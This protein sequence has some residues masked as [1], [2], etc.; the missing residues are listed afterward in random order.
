MNL[1]QKLMHIEMPDLKDSCAG[2]D[3]AAF[4]PNIP[5]TPHREPAETVVSALGSDL[6]LGL[7][8][9]EAQRRLGQYGP[10]R[11]EERA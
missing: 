7:T 8:R 5:I 4:G 6:A 1:H 2:R 10:N 11:F 9:A 3:S